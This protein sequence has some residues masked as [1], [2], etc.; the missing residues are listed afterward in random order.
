MTTA[1]Q[2]EFGKL[3]EEQVAEFNRQVVATLDRMSKNAPAGSEVGIAALKSGIAAVNSTY[4]NLSKVARQFAEVIADEL[5]NR[6][7][8]RN[9]RREKGDE[10]GL[11][12]IREMLDKAVPAVR[13]TSPLRER[14]RG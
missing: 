3:I 10:E 11:M 1:T 6:R 9:E 7:Q 12:S 13:L 2:V 4:D 8:A 5:R 14:G